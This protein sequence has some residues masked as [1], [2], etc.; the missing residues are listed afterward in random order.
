MSKIITTI[1]LGSNKIAA[2]TA[3]VDKNGKVSLIGAESLNSRGIEGGEILDIDKAVED[4]SSV[5][6]K[7]K[8]P[9]KKK[10][11]NVSIATRGTD[12]KMDLSRG[13]VPLSKTPREITKKDMN[14]CLDIASMQKLPL[15]RVVVEKVVKSF[16]IDGGP[17]GIKNPVGLYG[18]KL[19]AETFIATAKRSKIQNIAKC[20]DHAGLFINGIY[21]SSFASANSILGGNEKEKGV[22]L[23]DI[24][25]SLTEEIIFKNGMLTHFRILK[26]GASAILDNTAHVNKN[27]LDALLEEAREG[28]P[29]EKEAFS[30]VVVTGGGALLDG[31]IERAEKL[32]EAPAR[33]G[34]V[35]GAGRNLNS[36]DAIIHTSTLGLINRLAHERKSHRAFTNPIRKTLQKILDIYESYF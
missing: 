20:I 28:L 32:L 23:L 15:D 19:E 16:S 24:G 26:K 22:L 11:K 5:M 21:L 17:L 7:L 14:K 27:K 8:K 36:Q 9:L 30:S 29:A 31:V 13:M 25:G 6:D 18:I 34:I 10:I 33:I 1:D 35:R 2:A 12:I 4:I 3:A